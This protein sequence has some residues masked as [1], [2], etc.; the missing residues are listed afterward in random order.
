MSGS[1]VASV[2][3][4][5]QLAGGPE[6]GHR[7]KGRV[8]VVTGAGNGIGKAC[9]LSLAAEGARVVVNDLGTSASGT[10]QSSEAADAAVAEIRAAGGEAVASY[11]SV[12]D[13]RGVANLVAIAEEAFGPVDIALAIAGAVLPGQIDSTDEQYRKLMD[14]FLGQKFWLARATV[15]G[16]AERGYGRFVAAASE[17]ARGSVGNP[18]FAAAMG[19]TISMM[20]G[21]ATEYKDTGVTANTLAPGASTRTY[22]LMLPELER[23]HAEGRLSD[24]MWAAARKGPGPV[25][26]VPPIVTWLCTTEAAGVTGRVFH[27]GGGKVSVWTDYEDVNTISKG[28]PY[29]NAPWT[30]EELDKL[31]PGQLVR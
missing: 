10:G 28:D 18:L 26:H 11:D 7:L 17:G 23:A 15:P 4:W 30:L 20:K 25:E 9:A 19:G 5:A 14:L 8:A 16:M 24:A 29:E 27:S 6:V 31:V 13:P 22:E 3:P 1:C 12:A 2:T 21:L